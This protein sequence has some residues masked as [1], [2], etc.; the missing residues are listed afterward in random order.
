MSSRWGMKRTGAILCVVAGAFSAPLAPAL[1]RD[2]LGVFRDWG[3]FRDPGVPRC[4]AIAMPR[5]VPGRKIEFQPYLTVGTW[6]RRGLRNEVHV[7]LSRRTAAQ[8]RVSLTVAGQTFT[9][10]GA[11]SDAWAPDRRTDAAI[12]AAMRSAG[13]LTVAARGLDGR[14]V[15]DTYR[16]TGAATALDAAALACARG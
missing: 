15:R 10:T 8:S 16:L 1:A 5:A 12:V 14:I 4:Y 13:E 2:S 11:G 7:R 3:A 6:P 9:L